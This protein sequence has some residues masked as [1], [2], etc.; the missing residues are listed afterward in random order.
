MTPLQKNAGFQQDVHNFR[1]F[2]I[3]GVI[4]AHALQNFEWGEAS[5]TFVILDS[6]F[7]Q[8]TIWF[9]F[10][11]GYLFQYLGRNFN[12]RSYYSKKLKHV[13]VPYVFCSL[14]ALVA[15]M[16]FHEQNMPQGFYDSSLA[17]QGLLF[18][19][20]GQHLAPFWYIPMIAII[21]V[22][23][24]LLFAM[25]RKPVSY[26]CLL[27]LLPLSAVLGRDGLL[28]HTPLTGYYT[29]LSTALY[30]ISP[31][32]LG[33]AVSHYYREIMSLVRR[34][35]YVLLPISAAFYV[36]EVT[37]YRETT[38]YMFLFKVTSAPLILYFI[39]RRFGVT[40]RL[41]DAIAT[42]SFGL[43]FLHGYIL[44]GTKIVVAW[45]TNSNGIFEANILSYF[46]YGAIVTLGS[47]ACV[48]LVKRV[49]GRHSKLLIGC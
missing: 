36:A 45:I 32:I 11:A 8:S 18:L 19:V 49:T 4:G 27:G 20:T 12:T 9:A 24:P 22:L 40:Q 17:T 37:H 48:T 28:I 14:P 33:M 31:Y 34:H 25:D 38:Y 41:I 39:D 44:S 15:S 29:Q 26:L 43:F 5:M 2:A 46:T 35:W 13:I 1:A 10:I 6:L 3:L 47:L 30:L 42:L 21:F 16:T 7:N 23:A